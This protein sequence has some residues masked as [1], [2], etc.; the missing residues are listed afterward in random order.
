[1]TAPTDRFTPTTR[2]SAEDTAT[3]SAAP[4]RRSG[5]ILP[6]DRLADRRALLPWLLAVLCFADYAALGLRDQA[7]MLTS[8]FDLGIFDQAIRAYAHGHAPT[9]PLKG[10][11]F[12]LLGDHFSP[13][14]ALLAPL[15][16]IW[17]SADALL[18]A[19]AA[20]FALAAV[21]LTR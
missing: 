15:Y 18:I 19:Q 13:I 3:S 8:G 5:L 1:M 7:R 6:L 2:E 12:D 16:R 11:G 10:F 9:T 21:P 17:P 20:L 14:I 4:R